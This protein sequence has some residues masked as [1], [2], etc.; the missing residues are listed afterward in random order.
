VPLANMLHEKY[1]PK[2]YAKQ[3]EQIRMKLKDQKIVEETT[4]VMG[5]CVVNVLMQPLAVFVEASGYNAL[6]TNIEFLEKVNYTT[7]AQVII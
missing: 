4:D 3:Q 6:L 7:I 5:R 2:I 1:V